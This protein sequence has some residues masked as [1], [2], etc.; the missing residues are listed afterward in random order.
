MNIAIV[1]DAW[2]PQVSGVATTIEATK[3][4]LERM[5]HTVLVVGPS[6][7]KFTVPLP[8][9]PEI[10]LA[11]RA[12]RRLAKILDAFKPDAIHIAVEG[13]L[14]LA[15]HRYC[16]KRGMQF[17]TAYHTRFPEYL[18]VRTGIPV[19]W[20]YPIVRWFHG[21]AA[22]TMV[23]APLLKE[24]LEGRGFKNLVLWNRGVD[25]ELFR[26]DDPFPLPGTRPIFMHMGRVAP[27]KNI[28]AFLELDLPGTKY[29]VGDGPARRKLEKKYP[30]AVFTGYKFGRE[31]ARHL[32]AA[33]V[34]VF[35][36]L[37]DTLGLVMLEANACGVPVAAFPSEASR[38]VIEDGVNGVLSDDLRE[39]CMR[40]LMLSREKARET[41]LKFDWQKPTELFLEHLEQ[42][43]RY[44][45]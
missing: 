32:A 6:D 15:A 34:F 14:G 28:E 8:T 40:A 29:V 39:A 27:E 37:T 18:N 43:A 16:R 38:S 10:R 42:S 12:K 24:E 9:Y 5:G 23:A 7:F 45:V 35:P 26:P 21:K 19:S 3:R 13:P 33:D 11:L 44:H 22:R 20:I 17:T 4:E 31:L 2:F 25:A 36:S 1:T 30:E 41:A